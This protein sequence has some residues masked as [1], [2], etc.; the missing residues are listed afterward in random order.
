M[1]FQDY[2][3]D[4]KKETIVHKFSKDRC[5]LVTLESQPDVPLHVHNFDELVF[6]LGGSAVHTVDGDEYPIIRGDVFVV[7][8]N[9]KHGYD[10]PKNLNIVNVLYQREY[11]ESL[12]KIFADLPGFNALFVH[13]PLYRKKHKFKSKLHL[14]SQQLQRMSQLLNLMIL[15]QNDEWVGTPIS[16][17]N[18]FNLIVINVCKFFSEI[19]SPRSKALLKISAAIDF[20]ERNFDK[21]ISNVMLAN[22]ANI[23]EGSFR[24][25]FKR[26]TGLSPIDYLIRLRI[27]KAADMMAKNNRMRVID[28]A[29]NS[30]FEN[31][32]YFTRK[33][34][35]IIGMTPMA[36]LKK[37]RAMIE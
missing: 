7:K 9:Q 24:Y 34:K 5:E 11:F 36:Y 6:I 16:K 32:A 2:P 1:N 8:G 4:V 30:G 33:F 15:E 28:A 19:T 25:S 14:K 26:I 12:K 18:I 37:Q 35:E 31:S 27:E 3:H 17:E 20:I 29:F 13:E 22:K 10:N 23:P 21:P